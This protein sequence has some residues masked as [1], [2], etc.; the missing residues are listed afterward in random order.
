MYKNIF[1]DS[2]LTNETSRFEFSLYEGIY[3]ENNI[4]TID[5]IVLVEGYSESTVFNISGSNWKQN[6]IP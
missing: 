4:L 1:S 3:N 2:E 6:I 5:N